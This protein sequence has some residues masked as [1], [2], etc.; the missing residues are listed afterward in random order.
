[1]QLQAK[2][3]QGLKATPRSYKEVKYI[4]LILRESME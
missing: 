1:M 2:N 4:L 3:Q